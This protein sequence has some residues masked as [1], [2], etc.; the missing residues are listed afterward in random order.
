MY[1]NKFS[2]T[3]VNT[4]SKLLKETVLT[5]MVMSIVDYWFYEMPCSTHIFSFSC[6]LVLQIPQTQT[7]CQISKLKFLWRVWFFFQCGKKGQSWLQCDCDFFPFPFH[8][9]PSTMM[10]K[11][12]K[13]LSLKIL[14]ISICFFSM[15]FQT[16]HLSYDRQ[17]RYSQQ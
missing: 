10:I 7:Y 1:F 6:F 9:L 11:Y 12:I 5:C 16:I 15:H 17:G 13:A 8:N 3:G 4:R 14:V 2:K